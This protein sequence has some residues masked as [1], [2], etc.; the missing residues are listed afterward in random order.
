M[1]RLLAIVIITTS[2][3][4][5]SSRL[6]YFICIWESVSGSVC[7]AFDDPVPGVKQISKISDE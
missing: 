6:A 1:P 5:L 4:F 7:S 2:Y 3:Y